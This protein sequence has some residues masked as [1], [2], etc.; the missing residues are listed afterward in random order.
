M[1][2]GIE[3]GEESVMGGPHERHENEATAMLI[4][5]AEMEEFDLGESYLML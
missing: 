2:R 1:T 4:E 3:G 5:S